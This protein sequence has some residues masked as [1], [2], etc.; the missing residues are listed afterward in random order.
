MLYGLLIRQ[1]GEIIRQVEEMDFHSSFYTLVQGL[2]NS[3]G[4]ILPQF[5]NTSDRLIWLVY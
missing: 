1:V 2:Y 3:R 5:N 4:I